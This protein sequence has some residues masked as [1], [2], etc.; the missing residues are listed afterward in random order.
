MKKLLAI[1]M[2]TVLVF[3]FA[4]CSEDKKEEPKN[5]TGTQTSTETAEEKK[6]EV[7]EVVNKDGVKFAPDITTDGKLESKPLSDETIVICGK[8]YTLPIKMSD[9]MADG[10]ELGSD[11]FKNEF[12]PGMRIGTVG[13]Y[14]ENAEGYCIDLG[15]IY[16]DT[17]TV[18]EIKDCLLIELYIDDLSQE[19]KKADFVFPGGVTKGSTAKDV[20]SVYGDPNGSELFPE[21]SISLERQL[22]YNQHKD[23]GLSFMYTFNEDGLLDY[24]KVVFKMQ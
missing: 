5:Q 1:L 16:N 23:S 18:Q 3:G 4:G 19:N 8:E 2:A 7:K 17:E 13:F 10:W 6:F 15:A 21:S 12:K 24:A 11:N 9:L 14:M 20:L 22:T